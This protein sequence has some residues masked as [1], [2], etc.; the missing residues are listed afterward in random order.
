MVR[1]VRRRKGPRT[2]APW[3][4]S[5]PNDDTLQGEQLL[6][7][8]QLEQRCDADGVGERFERVISR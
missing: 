1:R 5:T 6:G 3:P 2:R 4:R 8:D 7:D